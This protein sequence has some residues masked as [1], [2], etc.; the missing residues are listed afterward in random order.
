MNKIVIRLALGCVLMFAGCAAAENALNR[1]APDKTQ[2]VTSTDSN[3]VQTN[4]VV[5]IPGTHTLTPTASAVINDVS[6]LAGPIS[7]FVMP[8][9]SLILL[10]INFFQ[11]TKNGKLSD[12]ISSTVQTIE[13]ASSDPT[14]APAIAILKTKLAQSHQIAGVQPII[15]NVL[16]D[17][18]LLPTP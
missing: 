5:D 16:A 7:P 13:N 1:V 3:G 8:I 10:G 11:K 15:N 9:V 14:I 6:P 12:A 4:S 17:L 18:K 2:V